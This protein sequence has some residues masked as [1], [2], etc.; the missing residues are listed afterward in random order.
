MELCD[1]SIWLDGWQIREKLERPTSS[2]RDASVF[3]PVSALE[4]NQTGQVKCD[5][6]I[7]WICF[8]A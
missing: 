4:K 8:F 3:R 1:A 2:A 7:N 5:S 6:I